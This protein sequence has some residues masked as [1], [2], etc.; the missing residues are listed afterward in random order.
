MEVR[1]EASFGRWANP[2]TV[3]PQSN[4]RS[5]FGTRM[6]DK[7]SRRCFFTIHSAEPCT[8]WEDKGKSS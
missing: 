4:V 3:S 5:G 6:K 1:E 8:G 2:Y 7:E